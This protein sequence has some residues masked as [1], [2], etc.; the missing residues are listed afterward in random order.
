MPSELAKKRKKVVE[1]KKYLV[2]TALK[3]KQLKTQN[4]H[5]KKLVLEQVKSLLEEERL[6][7]S[8]LHQW[9]NLIY[10]FRIIG[11]LFK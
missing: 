7:K 3:T 9:S 5:I 2:E 6:R 10:N 4:L 8:R 1:T 11:T